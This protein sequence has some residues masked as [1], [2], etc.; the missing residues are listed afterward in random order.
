MGQR[1]ACHEEHNTHT[2]RAV[3]PGCNPVTPTKV[4]G[5][6]GLASSRFDSCKTT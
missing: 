6:T 4:Y 2:H 3:E 1:G 5:N